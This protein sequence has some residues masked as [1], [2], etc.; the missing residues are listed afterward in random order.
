MHC[1][2]HHQLLNPDQL[3]PQL[4]EQALQLVL[5]QQL[6]QKLFAIVLVQ[7]QQQGQKL[8]QKRPRWKSEQ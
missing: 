6:G 8:E 3:L 2:C 1:S 5:V 7:E 4:R